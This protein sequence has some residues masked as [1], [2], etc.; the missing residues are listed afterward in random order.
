[1]TLLLLRR[2]LSGHPAIGGSHW[3][4]SKTLESLEGAC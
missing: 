4:L 3:N 1:M 2:M